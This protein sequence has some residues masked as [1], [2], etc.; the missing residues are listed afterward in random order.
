MGVKMVVSSINYW[1]CSFRWRVFTLENTAQH[2]MFHSSCGALSRCSDRNSVGVRG[3]A[4]HIWHAEGRQ[5]GTFGYLS[6]QETAQWTATCDL[7]ALMESSPVSF[8]QCPCLHERVHYDRHCLRSG[9]ERTTCDCCPDCL[10]INICT[11]TALLAP[12][13]KHSC[14]FC[15]FVCLNPL[16]A[17][18]RSFRTNKSLGCSGSQ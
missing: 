12:V 7:P 1:C 6:R 4:E 5:S 14:S 10:Y 11:L 9:C 15:F 3:S 13:G 2:L 8:L 16:P 18:G 17:M